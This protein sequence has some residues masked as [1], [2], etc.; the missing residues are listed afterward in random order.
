MYLHKTVLIREEICHFL[1]VLNSWKDVLPDD[2]TVNEFIA[3]ILKW[4]EE[5]FLDDVVWKRLKECVTSDVVERRAS[6]PKTESF[7]VAQHESHTE[8]NVNPESGNKRPAERCEGI[9]SNSS[10]GEESGTLL[11]PSQGKDINKGF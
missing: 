10:A 9:S 1:Q 4:D 8:K 3:E 11:P 5:G 2:Y 7:A 6:K